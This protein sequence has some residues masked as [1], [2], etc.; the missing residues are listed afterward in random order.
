MAE[1]EGNITATEGQQSGASET[2]IQEPVLEPSPQGNEPAAPQEQAGQESPITIGEDGEINVSDSFWD[3]PAAA[4][5][6]KAP[7]GG[8]GAKA[9]EPVVPA[10]TPP[11][12][13][14]TPEE[15]GA[16][17]AGGNIDETKIPPNL[18]EFYKAAMAALPAQTQAPVV[19]PQRVQAPAQAAMTPQ[20]YTQ[21]REA[22]KKVAA[23]NMLGIDPADFDEMDPGHAEAQRFAMGQIQS[24]A[25]EIASE[26]QAEA[27]NAQRLANEIRTLDAEYRQ[28]DPEFFAKH[29]VLMNNYLDRIPSREAAEAV[30]AIQIGDVAG[31][32]K[33]M[34]GVYRDYKKAGTVTAGAVPAAKAPP[35]V[36]KAGGSQEGR[37]AGFADAEDLAEMSDEERAEWLIQNKFAV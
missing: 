14:Y 31:I 36:M 13:Y 3:E 29:E 34:D 33:F 16:A 19:Q 1:S 7:E 5:E 23:Q 32:R 35:P 21:L 15:F 8:E 24:R 20:Q 30:R 4:A 28:K 2:Q 9:A 10:S 12:A 11:A 37:S 27:W 17:F 26:R 18:A 6:T 22:A 25:R